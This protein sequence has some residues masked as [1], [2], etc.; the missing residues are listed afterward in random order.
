MK[1]KEIT[2]AQYNVLLSVIPEYGELP[3][4]VFVNKTPLI[5]FR[6]ESDGTMS[7]YIV[8]IDTNTKYSTNCVKVLINIP[9]DID[10]FPTFEEYEER[11]QKEKQR[12]EYMRIQRESAWK[13][14]TFFE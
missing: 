4:Q 2:F 13:P 5:N 9:E 14:G 10:F 11:I 3:K 1:I 8:D 12:E 7:P 6:M